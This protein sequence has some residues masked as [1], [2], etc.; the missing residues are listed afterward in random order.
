MTTPEQERE[1]RLPFITDLQCPACESTGSLFVAKGGY[2]TCSVS[3]C[4]NPDY[5]EA[6]EQRDAQRE[7]VVLQQSSGTLSCK[8][9]IDLFFSLVY[10]IYKLNI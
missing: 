9:T 8:R 1:E 10:N 6:L 4:P 5:V 3:D 7:A 2:V